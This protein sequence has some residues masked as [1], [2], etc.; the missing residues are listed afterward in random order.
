MERVE[1]RAERADATLELCVEV[2]QPRSLSL[3][4]SSSVDKLADT[5]LRRNAAMTDL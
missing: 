3:A 1:W 4:S 2:L 5:M